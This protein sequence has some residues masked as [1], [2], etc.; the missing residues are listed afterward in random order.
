MEKTLEIQLK[1]LREELVKKIDNLYWETPHLCASNP[2]MI[3]VESVLELIRE[4][5]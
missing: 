2:R 1:E 4:H 5:K 3:N